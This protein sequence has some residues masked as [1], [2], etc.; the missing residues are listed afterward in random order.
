ML[1]RVNGFHWNRVARELDAQGNAV[2]EGLVSPDQCRIL[3]GLYG[4][5]DLF[6]TRVVMARHGFGRGEYKYFA[7]PCRI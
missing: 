1:E 7:Y 6:R 5:D 2:L 3:A 4:R